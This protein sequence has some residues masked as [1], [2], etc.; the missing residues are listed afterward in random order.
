M[1]D[2][3]QVGSWPSVRPQA[4]TA[5]D[6][7]G[8]GGVAAAARGRGGSGAIRAAATRGARTEIRERLTVRR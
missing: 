3:A 7:G 5:G 8:G 2:K 6:D 4:G 1:E